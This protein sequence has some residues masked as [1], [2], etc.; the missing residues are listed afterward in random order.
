[1]IDVNFDLKDNVFVILTG[2]WLGIDMRSTAKMD[3]TGIKVSGW[4]YKSVG[5]VERKQ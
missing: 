5:E 1:M 3:E 4:N 2:W